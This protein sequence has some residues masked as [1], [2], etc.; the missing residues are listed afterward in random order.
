MDQERSKRSWP[1]DF[2]FE[3]VV[4]QLDNGKTVVLT[5]KGKSMHPF[6]QEGERVSLKS[7]E[8][9]EVKPGLILLARHQ[10]QVLLHR[11]VKHRGKAICLAGDGNVVQE[12]W[13]Q[14]TEILATAIGVWRGDKWVGL[15][16]RRACL[17]GRFWYCLR[18]LR[19]LWGW[20]RN[21]LIKKL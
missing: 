2:L 8:S 15:T 14:E 7:A 4:E 5:V 10:G 12:E 19:R 20:K 6:L 11:Y 18:P 9:E 17:T 1:N 3:Q 21:Y 13:I 16:G